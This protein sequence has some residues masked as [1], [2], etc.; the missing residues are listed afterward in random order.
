M[1]KETEH[2]GGSMK[3]QV[4]NIPDISRDDPLFDDLDAAIKHALRQCHTDKPYGIWT[5]QD[6]GGELLMI[7]YMWEIF[8][9]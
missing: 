5:D 8:R 6:N 2:E 3:Y 1:G 4:G 7:V 9:K